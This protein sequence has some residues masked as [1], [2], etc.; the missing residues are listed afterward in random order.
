MITSLLARLLLPNMRK[1]RGLPGFVS[2]KINQPCCIFSDGEWTL[3]HDFPSCLY[4]VMLGL[5]I[6]LSTE[7][8]YSH[9]GQQTFVYH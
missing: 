3:H 7:K 8:G 5:Y 6:M 9:E 1:N 4:L 2:Y